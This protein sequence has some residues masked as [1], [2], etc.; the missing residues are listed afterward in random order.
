MEDWKAAVDVIGN[1]LGKSGTLLFNHGGFVCMKSSP[2]SIVR[3]T[4]TTRFEHVR[5]SKEA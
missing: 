5:N 3:E 2:P 4:T 1:P